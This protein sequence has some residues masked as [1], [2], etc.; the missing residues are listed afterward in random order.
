MMGLGAFPLPTK[1]LSHPKFFLFSS[2]HFSFLSN[3]LNQNKH[4]V[5]HL[6]QPFFFSPHFKKQNIMAFYLI[7]CK[8]KTKQ[9]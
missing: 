2:L 6:A 4:R 5:M 7:T 9:L 3:H 8:S 1:Q